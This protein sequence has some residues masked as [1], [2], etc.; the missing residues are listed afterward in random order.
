MLYILK[1]AKGDSRIKLKKKTADALQLNRA[2]AKL[3]LT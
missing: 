2:V 3:H 1:E